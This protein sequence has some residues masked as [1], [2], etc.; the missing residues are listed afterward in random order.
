MPAHH[1]DPYPWLAPFY[2]LSAKLMLLPFGGEDA[3][4]RAAVASMELRPGTPVLEL[5]CGTGSMTKLLLDAG[6][7]VTAVE[8]S[9]HMLE[10]ARRKAKGARFVAGDLLSYKPE[11][12]F[13]RVLLSFVLHEM[14]P[15]IRAQALATAHRALAPGG[16]LTVL[17]FARP[18][19]APMRLGLR[20]YLRVSEPP[21]ALDW[22][23]RGPSQELP[24]AGFAVVGLEPLALGTAVV[25]TGVAA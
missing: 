13:S 24:Q 10:R 3:F 7:D 14:T 16:R 9:P 20:A 6:A 25:A 1:H 12:P 11:R 8:L 18:E 4:R 17:D 15:E 21:Q 23:D 5:G 2:D 19:L 22:L